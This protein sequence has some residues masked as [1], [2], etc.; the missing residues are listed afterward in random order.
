[1][2]TVEATQCDFLSYLVYCFIITSESFYRQLYNFASCHRR[3][4]EPV[5]KWGVGVILPVNKGALKNYTCM[6]KLNTYTIYVKNAN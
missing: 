3:R 2:K 5:K 1:M 4:G 6:L